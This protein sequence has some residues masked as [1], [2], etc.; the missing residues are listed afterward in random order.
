MITHAYIPSFL[1]NSTNPKVQHY[2]CQILLLYTHT[3]PIPKPQP[4]NYTFLGVSSLALVNLRHLILQSSSGKIIPDIIAN[5]QTTAENPLTTF[6]H[7]LTVLF[8]HNR[9][10]SIHHYIK[11]VLHYVILIDRSREKRV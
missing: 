2:C 7:S 10:F 8:P 11:T 3:H 6:A 5:Y 1:L 9:I 4:C